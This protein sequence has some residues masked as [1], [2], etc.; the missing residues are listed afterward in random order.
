MAAVDYAYPWDE[1][2]ARFKFRDEPGWAGPLAARML[3]APDAKPLLLGSDWLVPV[4]LSPAR[5]ASR[6]YN[7]AWELVKALR[8]QVPDAPAGLPDALIRLGEAPDQ[9]SLPREQRLR[10]R[11]GAFAARPEH[12]QRLRGRSILLVDDVS[13]TGAT[14]RSAAQAL[15]QAGAAEVGALVVAR[16]LPH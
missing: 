13:T 11:L 15:R 8:R 3:Q 4:P 12:L 9:H 7:Q 14:L 16:T 6:G 1:L 5:L 10:N 2:I